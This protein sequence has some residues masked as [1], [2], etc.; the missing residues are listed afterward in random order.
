MI[1]PL[2]EMEFFSV[3]FEQF[4]KELVSK[5]PVYI[6]FSGSNGLQRAKVVEDFEKIAIGDGKNPSLGVGWNP[7]C[8]RIEVQ[9]SKHLPQ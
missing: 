9:S 6:Y 1:T 2:T 4:F 3:A 7:R 8:P 5:N